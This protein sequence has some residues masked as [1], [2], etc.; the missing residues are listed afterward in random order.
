MYYLCT[1]GDF[2]RYVFGKTVYPREGH[3][4]PR[5]QRDYQL[6]I[7][8]SGHVRITV[9][10]TVYELRPG[11]GVLLCPGHREFFRF[12]EKEESEHSWCQVAPELLSREDK[13]LLRSAGGVHNV[14]ASVHLLIE[15][16]LAVRHH[17]NEELHDAMQALARACLLRQAAHAR[18]LER[19]G[20]SAPLHPALERALEM[21]ATHYAELRSAED[22]AARAGISA[23][24]LRSLCRQAGRESPSDMIWRLKV[25]HAIQMIRSTGLTLGEIAESC[26]YANPFHL[27]RSVKKATGYSPRRLRQEEWNR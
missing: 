5:V 25:E 10:K 8:I 7:L 3:C 17:G 23:N 1:S 9:D 14:P 26:G 18:S 24:Q 2:T 15:E 19:K 21:G 27:S 16:G 13:R 20:S 4:G 12:S 6:I 11:E 22:L